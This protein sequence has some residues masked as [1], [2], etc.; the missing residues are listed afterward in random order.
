MHPD[1]A[2]ERLADSSLN[3]MLDVMETVVVSEEF[4]MAI[5]QI[6]IALIGFSG[7][8]TALG[9]DKARKWTASEM[10]QLRT[11]VE[12]SLCALFGALVPSTVALLGVSFEV[13]YHLTARSAS[14]KRWS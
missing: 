11:Q 10:L 3:R 14:M 2:T 5:S 12:P 8:V 7:V 13:L 6:A 1:D 9:H 4:L